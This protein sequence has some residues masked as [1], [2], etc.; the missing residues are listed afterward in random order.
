M[1]RLFASILIEVDS[2]QADRIM[3]NVTWL[4]SFEDGQLLAKGGDLQRK[5]VPR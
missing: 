1:S 5:T 3:A 2:L 4:F